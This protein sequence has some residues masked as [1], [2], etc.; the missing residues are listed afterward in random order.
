[1][2]SADTGRA[3]RRVPFAR[4]LADRER[5]VRPTL[6]NERCFWECG[7]TMVAGIDEVGRGALAGPLVAA[8]VIL[9]ACTGR[10]QS[11]LLR[12][13][14]GVRDSKTVPAN[15]RPALMCRISNT[16]LA[17]GIGIVD[18]DELDTIGVGA[19]NR[20]ALQYAAQ[21]LPVSVH[22][23]L[24]DAC[25]IDLPIPQV[26]LIGGDA[27]S[28][29]IAAASIVAKVTRDRF[30]AEAHH[31]DRRYGFDQHK[32]YGTAD[33]LLA[34]RRHGPGPIHRRSF[35]PVRRQVGP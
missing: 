30:M 26:G 18:I 23:L 35:E 5:A 10:A 25:V 27:L 9:P 20:L 21:A 11:Q 24:L 28:L 12:T 31:D 16:A 33:H 6:V 29:S 17:I 2:T 19:A 13:L 3:G 34:L 7:L 32:G 8:A 22:V 14:E 4:R 1:M 15:Q